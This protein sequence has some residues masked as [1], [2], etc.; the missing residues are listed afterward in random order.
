MHCDELHDEIVSH[1]AEG[2]YEFEIQLKTNLARFVC[3][4]IVLKCEN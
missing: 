4:P 3:F 1:I 2:S